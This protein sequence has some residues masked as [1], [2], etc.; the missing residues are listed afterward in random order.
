MIMGFYEFF[1]LRK[2]RNNTLSSAVNGGGVVCKISVT[3][4]RSVKYV[5]SASLCKNLMMA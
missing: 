1:P 3:H 2:L 4:L 5:F